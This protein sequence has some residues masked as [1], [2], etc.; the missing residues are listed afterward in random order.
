MNSI[1]IKDLKG[2]HVHFIGIGGISMS[3]L[4]E[5]LFRN[6]YKVTGSDIAESYITKDLTN[7]GIPV[8]I[9][10][11]ASN[12]EGA[13]LVVYTAAIITNGKN[14]EMEQAKKTEYTY[15][16][17]CRIVRSNNG[18]IPARDRHIWNPWKN[19]NYFHAF[20]N[21]GKSKFRSHHIFR[22]KTG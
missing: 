10:H 17:S 22:R 9:G 1:H 4:A 14:S 6:G 21:Y 15:N 16:E 11:K 7:K 12:V 2:A 20:S 18:R 5:F 8:T 13:D 3:G 19:Y